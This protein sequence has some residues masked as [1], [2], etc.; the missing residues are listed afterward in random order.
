[1][2]QT[3]KNYYVYFLLS[4]F[5]LT[6]LPSAAADPIVVDPRF[7]VEKIVS[8]LSWPVQIHFVGDDM[9]ILQKN[10]G[11]VK[12]VR[13]GIL[14]EKPVLQ[15][16]VHNIGHTGL[17]GITS[18]DNFVYLYATQSTDN[19]NEPFVNR[20]YKY[21]W[22]GNN[23]V[24]PNLINE[25]PAGTG[26][27]HS[28]GVMVTGLDDTV[29]A[30]I[31]DTITHNGTLQNNGGN[32]PDDSSIILHV[33]AE[34]SVIRPYLSENVL[35]HY[36][37]MGIRNSYGLT[38]DP[39]TGNLWETENGSY[40]ND[41]I[42]LI[43]PKF[44]G[45][46]N[47]IMGFAS[48]ETISSLPEFDDF[49]YADPQ[50]VFEQPVAPTGLSFIKSKWFEGYENTLFVGGLNT[51]IIYKFPLNES[52]T[53]FSFVTPELKDLTFNP[54][55]PIDE[56]MFG[57]GFEG[58]VDIKSGPDGFLYVSTVFD[59]S[60]IYKIFPTILDHSELSPAKQFSS[61]VMPHKVTCPDGFVLLEKSS[62]PGVGCTTPKTSIQLIERN[63]GKITDI[64]PIDHC[65][66]PPAESINWSGC[67][68]SFVDFSGMNLQSVNLS[69]ANLAGANFSK[70]NLKNSNFESSTLT[71]VDLSFADLTKSNLVKSDLSQSDLEGA[72]LNK[73]DL[74]SVR[75]KYANVVNAF[76]IESDL[77]YSYLTFS[78]F[79]GS[80][81]TGAD[82]FNAQ[83]PNAN[84]ANTNLN[85]THFGMSDLF[86]VNL[87][88]ALISNTNFEDANLRE[89]VMTES[90][91]DNAYWN[92]CEGN[93]HCN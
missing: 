55:D 31:G 38:I 6:L 12:L 17:L 86:R 35:D 10:D 11:Q 90:M 41:E 16:D 74:K 76:L 1:V 40:D 2:I 78:N 65:N 30:V 4:I 87:S 56:I 81:F 88:N 89:T 67:D 60:S 69:G 42:N 53:G 58:I 63:W 9:M 48:P 46:W 84:L 73:S 70:S 44:N 49:K 61:G 93:P 82:V 71:N 19:P 75:L 13:D 26:F 29:F 22:D 59:E 64:K 77:K 39:F 21:E 79:E 3:I 68:F 85:N 23:L 7:T 83:L 24:N 15:I 34:E 52:R 36:F 51:G 8:G 80:D 14:Q 62:K 37:G 33:E 25:L 47:K 5:L 66:N 57:T 91:I 54:N 28:G 18:V 20:I 43:T 45:G 92:G 50:F 32:A 27:D 72:I